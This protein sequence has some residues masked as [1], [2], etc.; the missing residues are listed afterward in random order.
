MHPSSE[1]GKVPLYIEVTNHT[2][3]NNIDV[4]WIDYK[5]NEIRKG[6]IPNRGGVWS[7]TTYVGHPWTFRIGDNEKSVDHEENVL[8]KY[9]PFRVVPS[10]VG[11]ETSRVEPNGNVEGMQTFVIRDVPLGHHIMTTSN[12]N[13]EE[14]GVMVPVCWVE[15]KVLP[16]PPLTTLVSNNDS[17]LTSSS[18]EIQHAVHWSCQQIQ[19]EDAI[20]HGKGITSAKRLLQY[21]KNICLHPDEPKYRRLRLGNRIFQETIYNTGARGV[22][23]ALGFE[24]LYGYMECGPGGGGEGGNNMLGHDRIQQISDA[25]VVV[26]ETLMIMEGDGNGDGSDVLAQPEGGDGFGRAGFGHAGGMNL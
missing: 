21:L 26:N 2:S 20:Y 3:H 6:S 19:R 11:A 9:A 15:D 4:Y 1:R 24:E 14:Q 7:Q 16:E 17:R 10:I 5:G 23:L 25:M 22:L 13:T 18:P 12:N 8:L